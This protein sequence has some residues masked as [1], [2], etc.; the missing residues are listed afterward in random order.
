MPALNERS[1]LVIATLMNILLACEL[2][3]NVQAEDNST[4]VRIVT[5]DR[6]AIEKFYLESITQLQQE[7]REFLQGFFNNIESSL[8]DLSSEQLSALIKMSEDS[9]LISPVSAP[10]FIQA[11]RQY[12]IASEATRS[13][14]E[15]VSK[16]S[17]GGL[18]SQIKF[19]EKSSSK[20]ERM[21][22]YK[23]L[24][25]SKLVEFFGSQ[26]D[27]LDRHAKDLGYRVKYANSQ[28]FT[29]AAE[30]GE[31]LSLPK[32]PLPISPEELLS[33]R[34]KIHS[35]RRW[36]YASK[37]TI[38]DYTRFLRIKVQTFIETYGSSEKYR[39]SGREINKR[40]KEEAEAIAEAFWTRSYL[41]K[42]YGMP[43]GAIG[44]TYHKRWANLDHFTVPNEGL[45]EFLENPGWSENDRMI[46]RDAYAN[47]LRV[48]DARSGTILD[49]NMNF[50]AR[51][52]QLLNFLYGE[53]D[54]ANT[55]QMMLRL[56]AADLY[57][58][59]LISQAGGKAKMIHHYNSRYLVTP[60]DITYYNRLRQ[61]YDPDSAQQA[62]NE[63]DFYAD[64]GVSAT[65]GSSLLSHFTRVRDVCK[66]MEY[67]LSIAD[68]EEKDL[69]VYDGVTNSSYARRRAKSDY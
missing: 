7:D 18:P 38:D 50:L 9:M 11:V 44:F 55:A 17:Q 26:I 6:S 54:F 28:I 52:N 43:L 1:K 19:K 36:S 40:R 12:R 42:F 59:T 64:V 62:A 20:N 58:E 68:N 29:I 32:S 41:R 57:E 63:D 13:D 34:R 51:A 33:R 10:D 30:S 31:G 4:D 61:Q 25:F 3:N 16:L 49:G 67:N 5:Y 22:T 8:K 39:F 45:T 53:Y 35:L 23:G 47:A 15:K 60:E 66:S 69:A 48:A 46:F 24:D 2:E 65:G 21:A 37:Q 56:L 14:I 27:K